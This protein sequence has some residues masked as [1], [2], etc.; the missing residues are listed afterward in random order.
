[1]LAEGLAATEGDG[2]HNEDN[3]GTEIYPNVWLHCL[4]DHAGEGEHA[5]YSEGEQQLERHDAKNLS[6]KREKA[7]FCFLN[8]RYNFITK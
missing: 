2:D 8:Y 7:E 1:M 5:H 3:E 4:F 6:R